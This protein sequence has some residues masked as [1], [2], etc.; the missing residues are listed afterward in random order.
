MTELSELEGARK[1]RFPQAVK[2]QLATLAEG[3]PEGEGWIHEIKFDG[4][5]FVALINEGEVRLITRNGHDWT[6]KFRGIAKA[7]EE[8]PVKNA[9]VDGEVVALN[10][11]GQSDFQLLQNTLKG[12]KDAEVVYYLFDVM[13]LDGFNLTQCE[14]LDRKAVV[15]ELLRGMDAAGAIRLSEHFTQPGKAVWTKACQL[16]IEGIISKRADSRYVQKRSADWLKVKC[17]SREEM[18]IGGFTKPAGGRTGL[19]ALLMGQYD[20]ETGKLMYAGKVGTGF[21]DASLKELTGKLKQIARKDAAFENPPV[22]GW[23][24]GVTWVKPD[25][26]AEIAYAQVT[27]DG[28]LRHAVFHGLRED[29]RAKDV[30]V[31]GDRSE[32]EQEAVVESKRKLAGA[33]KAKKAA[34]RNAEKRSGGESAVR[35]TNPDRVLYPETGATKQDLADYYQAVMPRML[36]HVEGRLVSLVRCPDGRGKVCFYQ[37]H[38]SGHGEAAGLAEVKMKNSKGEVER[39]FAVQ[40]PDGLMSMVQNS[41][42]E[43]HGWQCT[44]KNVERPDR[45]V[46]DLDP[47]EGI[48]WKE[49]AGAARELRAVIEGYGLATYV[50][51]TGGKGLHVVVPLKPVAGWD[52]VTEF[53]RAV[54]E[55]MVAEQPEKYT[56][57]MSKAKRKG[58]IF[59]D[60]FR[61]ARS[62]TS[63]VPYSSRAREGATVATPL[64]WSEVGSI[65][66]KKLTIATV[67]GRVARQKSDPWGDFFKDAAALKKAVVARAV[68]RK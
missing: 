27:R 62:S 28:L 6:Q 35:F 11:D 52:D 4:Y 12:P 3:A 32:E 13:H 14:L 21:T 34:R 48:G 44:V 10:G 1:A 42:L 59:I 23:V 31:A 2:P 18:V 54:A 60:F 15:Q 58:K 37:R 63:I 43:V 67:P 22:G 57:T 25:L 55:G 8:L 19:G 24:K 20:P 36:L 30:V 65:N 64:R 50:M 61:N 5:R 41:A 45:I 39:Y 40:G 9:V 33:E 68:K 49:L 38:L 7:L 56:A 26:V 47:D 16:G 46:F 29:K 66:P 51:T 17:I 53:A